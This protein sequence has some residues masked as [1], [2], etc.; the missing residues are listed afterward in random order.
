[1]HPTLDSTGQWLSF[2][3][4][5]VVVDG[6]AQVIETLSG[7]AFRC[8]PACRTKPPSTSTA[9]AAVLRATTWPT[10]PPPPQPRPGRWCP[11]TRCSP[12]PPPLDQSGSIAQSDPTGARLLSGKALLDGLAGQDQALL[13]AFASDAGAL[14]PTVPL[15]VYGPFRDV[16]EAP[17]SFTTI[18]TLATRVGGNTPL[19]ESIDALR[20][21]WLGGGP[22]ADG[23]GKA[24]VVFT[25]DADTACA[26]QAACRT[27]RTQSMLG[28]Q[29]DQ[30]RL[31]MIGLSSGVD[32]A[33][34]GEQAHR[35]GGA[36]LFADNAAQLLPLY[37]SVGRLMSLSLPTYR[38]RWTVRAD[39]AGGFQAGQAL[40]GRVQVTAAGGSFDVPLV[41]GIP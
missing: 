37:G 18:D 30:V 32:M 8:T 2:E 25:D 4:E 39:A 31:F 16:N 12:M 28:A 24:M 41:V 40:L 23:L 9:C 27:R 13:A 35:S 5:L 15:T 38:L 6:D 17:D 22:R 21:Q 34:P 20:T 7:A 10:H 29:Q 14:L 36:L 1:L 3:I 11:A 33:A 19:Y 26:D